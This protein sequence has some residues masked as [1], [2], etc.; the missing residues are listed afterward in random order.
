MTTEDITTP[1]P[2]S[3]TVDFDH[4]SP[5]MPDRNWTVFAQLRTDC[6]VAYTEAHNGFWMISGHDEVQRAA[7]DDATFSSAND[8]V[9]RL[10]VALPPMP[11]KAGIIET[12]PP[13]FTKLRKAFVPWFSPGA[14]EARRANIQQIT[15]YCID[16]MIE[17]GHGDLTEGI[18]SPVPGLL[19]MQFLGFSPADSAW[20][21]DLFH[22]HS[23]V[24]PHTPERDQV[25]RDVEQLGVQ[26]YERAAAC[27]E[28][29]TDDFLSFLANLCIDGELL[30]LQEVAEHA[31]LV[32]AGGIDT[33]TALMSNTL[34]HLDEH[35]ELRPRLLA[36]PELMSTAFDEYLRYYSPVQGLARTITASCTWAGQDLRE[37][38]RAW[39][40]WASANHD[41][42][43][44]PDSESIRLERTPNRHMAFGVG[45]HRCL[46]ANL[47]KVTWQTVITSVLTRLPDYAVDR[48]ACRRFTTIGVINGW[49]ATPATFLPGPTVDARLPL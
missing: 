3:A 37:N 25:D 1:T 21:G 32:L 19:T 18:T 10:G 26:L 45:V 5:E 8:L 23:Y 38:D 4:H 22:R 28:R 6:P 49:I 48:A 29:P 11:A 9:S 17:Q 39:L 15:D 42:S 20:M 30:S 41:D 24:P 34:L 35:P 46:G 14:A 47:A 31:F 44:F 43:V 36:E 13:Y 12:D 16:Q 27:R 40:S 33:T 7:R 2:R